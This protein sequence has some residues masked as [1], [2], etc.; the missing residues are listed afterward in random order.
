LNGSH[1][2]FDVAISV[3]RVHKTGKFRC[4][5][6]VADTGQHFGEAGEPE[7]GQRMT[8]RQQRGAADIE[9]LEAGAFDQPRRQGIM[10]QRAD[11]GLMRAVKFTKRRHWVRY[12]M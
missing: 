1:D 6:D 12:S 9:G 11:Q 5:D 2:A 10:G 4:F 7:I 8:G 3:I